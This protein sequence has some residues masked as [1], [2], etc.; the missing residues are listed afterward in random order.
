MVGPGGRRGAARVE[1]QLSFT[2]T[3][4]PTRTVFN[5]TIS[6]ATGVH[7]SSTA[8]YTALTSPLLRSHAPAG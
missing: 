4:T 1:P 5:A 2:F 8:T 3:I 7:Q 6:L